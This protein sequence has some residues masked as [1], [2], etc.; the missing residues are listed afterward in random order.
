MSRTRRLK[1]QNELLKKQVVLLAKE[2]DRRILGDKR[3]D[4]KV[5]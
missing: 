1:K 3:D 5:V 4:M 2:L